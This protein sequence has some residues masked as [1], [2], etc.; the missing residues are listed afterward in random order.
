MLVKL[1][2]K[3]DISSR[4]IKLC[5]SEYEKNQ[6]STI[7]DQDTL[8]KFKP[9]LHFNIPWMHK[10]RCGISIEEIDPKIAPPQCKCNVYSFGIKR[11]EIQSR[12]IEFKMLLN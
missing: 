4:R 3:R 10:K 7:H 2:Q 12:L 5:N 11:S 1:F 6:I 8:T 9:M